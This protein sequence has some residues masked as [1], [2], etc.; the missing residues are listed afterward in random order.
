MK[1][2]DDNAP[3]RLKLPSK[4]ESLD[5]FQEF[6]RG[7]IRDSG[8]SQETRF[9]I[10]LALEE[11][12]VNIMH[13]AY[14]GG[15]T[16]WIELTCRLE[17][18]RTRLCV[19]IRDGGRPFNPFECEH[20]DIGASLEQRPVGGLGIFLIRK[21]TQQADYRRDADVNVLTMRFHLDGA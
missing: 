17:E 1:R 21:M 19:E 15:E 7:Q 12:L 8:C 2:P 13:Y 14:P 5:R 18:N 3:V 16:G 4:L 6:I 10:Q 11:A 20:P 9:N